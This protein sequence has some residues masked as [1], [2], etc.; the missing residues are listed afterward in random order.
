MMDIR[1]TE[2]L[3]STYTRVTAA[4]NVG[5]KI[6]QQRRAAS[7]A[8]ARRKALAALRDKNKYEYKGSVTLRG[9][10]RLVAGITINLKNF[11]AF[12]GTYIIEKATH[13][14]TS[15]GYTTTIEVRRVL[16]GY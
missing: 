4:R 13:N 16:E 14:V 7:M 9:D 3:N 2:M 8:E 6:Q 15:S 11:A 5:T 10:I 1:L 12:T